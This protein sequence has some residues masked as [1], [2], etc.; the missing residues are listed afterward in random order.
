MI[1]VF[2]FFTI[3]FLYC[4]DFLYALL[5]LILHET[6]EEYASYIISEISNS[7][8]ALVALVIFSLLNYLKKS[9]NF[10][11]ISMKALMILKVLLN[12]VFFGIGI[13]VR[14]L[15]TDAF[16]TFSIISDGFTSLFFDYPLIFLLLSVTLEKDT[17]I[18]KEEYEILK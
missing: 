17:D 3:V 8:D 16:L 7:L 18:K 10:T 15:S 1:R 13:Y 4:S 12:A 9:N 14:T 5:T 6:G 11:N 2:L